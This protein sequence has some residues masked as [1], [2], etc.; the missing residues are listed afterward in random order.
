MGR[1]REG[2]L[3]LVRA[4]TS[5]GKGNEGETL[6]ILS[7]YAPLIQREVGRFPEGRRED[8]SQEIT[9]NLL[10]A[11]R[12]FRP[13]LEPRPHRTRHIQRSPSR[14]GRKGA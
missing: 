8:A 6:R 1:R 13:P 14:L 4:L 9:L 5:A 10:E 12:K 3:T 2:R 11:L 7:A